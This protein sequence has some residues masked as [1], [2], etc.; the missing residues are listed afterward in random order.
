M[1]EQNFSN[2]AR[3]VP[4]FHFVLSLLLLIGLIASI[5]NVWILLNREQYVFNAML[6]VLLFIAA[7]F[8]FIFTRQFAIKVQDR[9]IR[10]EE[11]FRYFI[12]TGKAIDER[13]TIGQI[14]ALR[15]ASNEEYLSLVERAANESLKP[16][17]I[18]KAI[19][20]WRSDNHR[21]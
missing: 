12:L 15:F 1:R 3:F 17:E 11:N 21:A 8:S 10:A 7:I 14:I 19:K 16:I 6:I 18:K 9:A 20:N 2:H 4:G 5:V 13:I